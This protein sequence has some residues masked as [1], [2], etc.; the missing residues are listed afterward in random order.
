[1]PKLNV[2]WN[3]NTK[4]YAIAEYYDAPRYRVEILT[5]WS[6][7]IESDESVTVVGEDDDHYIPMDTVFANKMTA[8]SVAHAMNQN[9]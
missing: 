2:P 8:Q 6:Y 3:L 9:C 5:N 1:M 7:L 4:L